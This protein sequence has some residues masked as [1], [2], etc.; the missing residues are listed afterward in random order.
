MGWRMIK[1]EKLKNTGVYYDYENDTINIIVM[2][3]FEMLY[4]G[5]TYY[6]TFYTYPFQDIKYPFI[7]LGEF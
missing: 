5:E 1:A 2:N 7:Y 6:R 4:N 3:G